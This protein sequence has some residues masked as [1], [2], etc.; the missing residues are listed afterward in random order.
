MSETSHAL[1]AIEAM[2]TAAFRTGMMARRLLAEHPDLPVKEIRPGFVSGGKAEVCV[3]V[4]DC[5]GVRAWAERLGLRAESE[6]RSYTVVSGYE[7]VY[8]STNAKGVLD[9]I[10]IE[11]LG[12]RVVDGAERE[13]WIAERDRT[14]AEPEPAPAGGEGR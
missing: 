11:L 1:A 12:T 9:G 5:D 10:G 4:D 3:T 6:I 14:A 7:N 2:E 8:E 13:A